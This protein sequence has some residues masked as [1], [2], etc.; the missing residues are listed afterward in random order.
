MAASG[1]PTSWIA[2]AVMVSPK[3]EQV[4]R[5]N[6]SEPERGTLDKPV[7]CSMRHLLMLQFAVGGHFRRIRSFR[8]ALSRFQTTRIVCAIN[9]K[10]GDGVN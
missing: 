1:G 4:Q 5:G 8:S 9:S 7:D 6:R 2:L 3:L 10:E